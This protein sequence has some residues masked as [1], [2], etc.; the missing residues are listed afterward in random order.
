MRKGST[1]SEEAKLKIS[2][3]TK[4]IKRTQE[5]R[6]NMS[7]C[8]R[9]EN[10][11]NWQGGITA[12]SKKIRHSFEY[13]LWREAIFERDNWTCQECQ[14]RDGSELHPHHIKPFAL[15]PELR[16]EIDNGI[17]LCK[18]CHKQTDTFAGKT[19]KIK[20]L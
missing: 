3:A 20:Q 18:E 4:G 13:R 16:F 8:K 14:K 6:L 11:P 2:I 10:H 15:Y 1:L 5:A 17:T 12:E 9:G 7:I 19:N